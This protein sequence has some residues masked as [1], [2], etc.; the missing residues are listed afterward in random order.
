MA[1]K[2]KVYSGNLDGNH[3]GIIATTSK[4]RAASLLGISMYAFNEYFDETTYEPYVTLALS[5][6]GVPY[7]HNY[8][9]KNKGIQE[10]KLLS[11]RWP[12]Y[13]K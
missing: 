2:L 9:L 7:I 3:E 4:G 12:T 1:K 10:Y 13:P 11:E 6:P 5:N 8:K